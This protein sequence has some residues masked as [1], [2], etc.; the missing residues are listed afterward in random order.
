MTIDAFSD[1]PNIS[2]GFEI[3]FSHKDMIYITIDVLFFWI[4]FTF[5]RKGDK[6]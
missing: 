2:F 3:I 4:R 1:F 6:R 5:R